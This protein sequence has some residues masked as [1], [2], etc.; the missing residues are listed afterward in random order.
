MFFEYEFCK[1]LVLL[2][3]LQELLLLYKLV[4]VLTKEKNH[5]GLYELFLED[6]QNLH[7]L[8]QLHLQPFSLLLP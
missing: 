2:Y 5:S 7:L 6:S 1:K 8:H 4:K 3:Y